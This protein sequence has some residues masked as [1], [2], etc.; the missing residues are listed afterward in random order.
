MIRTLLNTIPRL[1]ILRGPARGFLWVP[2]TSSHAVW[3]GTYE[4]HNVETLRQLV[5]PGMNVWD[6]GANVGAMALILA[7]LVGR[8]GQVLAI[9]P[10]VRN[11]ARL[12][13]HVRQAS[14]VQ[15]VQKAVSDREGLASFEGDGRS[16][17]HLSATGALKVRVATLDSLIN[18]HGAPQLV[19]VDIEGH[20]LPAFQGA[21]RLLTEARPTLVVE[22]HGMGMRHSPPR[23]I[24]GEAR[25]LVASY[26][27]SWRPTRGG[28]YIAEPN[29]V[30]AETSNR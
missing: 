27:Y 24:D 29:G 7:R 5:R 16:D 12:R 21:T 13:E 28:W 26:G 15:V 17:G 14:N 11:A 18:D 25:D 1:P 22:F 4:R 8:H 10:G 19:K 6:V 3:L 9:E 30:P 2:Q 20:E 23:D